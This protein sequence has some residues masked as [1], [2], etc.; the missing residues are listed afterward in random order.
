MYFKKKKKQNVHIPGTCAGLP[1]EKLC[2]LKCHYCDR[3][4]TKLSHLTTIKPPCT[5]H[6][7][8][9]SYQQ[10]SAA[11]I[12]FT[13]LG[14]RRTQ[15]KKKSSEQMKKEKKI[16]QHNHK[17]TWNLLIGWMALYKQKKCMD[18]QFYLTVAQ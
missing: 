12:S 13:F 17:G 1:F 10:S 11:R 4:C 2:C 5:K 16:C 3:M 15:K 8:W 18:V 14:S 7:T 6:N 9:E